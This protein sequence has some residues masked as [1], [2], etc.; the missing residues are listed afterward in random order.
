MAAF[1]APQALQDL[2]YRYAQAVDRRDADRL[3][4]LFTADGAVR[5]YGE[6]PI[7]FRGEAELRR[8]IDQ[9]AIFQLTLHNVHNQTFEIDPAGH[10]TG[11]TTCIANH[12][13]PGE[14]WQLMV[15]AIR[16]HNH[17]ALEG[18]DWRFAD[19]ALEIIW[20]EQRPVSKFAPSMMDASLKEFQ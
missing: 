11:E 18:D 8:M 9:L 12:V 1:T 17:Y 14:P 2:A 3:V 13:L 7:A 16:Y 6:N 10:V 20:V 15:M 4:A 5:G 19:R